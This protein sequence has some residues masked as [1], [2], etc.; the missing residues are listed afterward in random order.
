MELD[1]STIKDF[2]DEKAD[3]YNRPEFIETDPVQIPHRY[4]FRED[5]E[6][7][8]FL[9][10]VIAWGGRKSI[11]KSAREMMRR[12]GDTPYD[13]V[14]S[15]REHDLEHLDGFVYRTFQAE[16][17]RVFIRALKDIYLNKGGLEGIFKRYQSE[18]SLQPAIHRLKTEFFSVPHPVRTRKHLPDPCR[19]SAAKR[20]NLFLRW[21]VRCDGRGVDFGL[22][23]DISPSILSCPLDVHSGR[24][25]RA[26]GLLQRTQND[27]K[28]VVELD[29]SLR[30]L[31]PQDPV[32]YDFA[33]FGLGVFEGSFGDLVVFS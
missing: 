4:S 3:Y 9:T 2:L 13:F 26:L 33:L 11:L 6:I 10:A 16:D 28:A 23:K 27:A 14:I 29:E 18:H 25:A 21:M 12:M 31:D 22:W 30:R 24:V 15:H 20:I 19:G 17:F 7:A 32:R 8:G 1:L 5:I